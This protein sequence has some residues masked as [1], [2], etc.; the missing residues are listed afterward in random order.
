MSNQ[1]LLLDLN[2]ERKMLQDAYEI[3]Q[4]YKTC[5]SA[6]T[7]A[8][9]MLATE[10]DVD[11]IEMAREQLDDAAARESKILERIRIAMLPKDP[12]DDK[13]IFLEIRPGAGGDESGLF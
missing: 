12:N 8:K 10:S 5:I 6:Q 9:E 7:E 4:E 3:Y 1:K 11:M 13:N 2:R